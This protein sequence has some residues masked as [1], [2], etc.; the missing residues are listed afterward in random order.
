MIIA[1]TLSNYNNKHV[2]VNAPIINNV[3]WDGTFEKIIYSNELITLDGI[4]L[5]IPIICT[6]GDKYYNKTK[7]VFNPHLYTNIIEQLRS[8]EHN[9]LSLSSTNIYKQPSIYEQLKNG[10]IKVNDSE[11]G[12]PEGSDD[13]LYTFVLKMSGI[14]EKYNC[15]G[16]TFKFILQKCT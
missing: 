13:D 1:N 2:Y 6:K 3:M 16:I 15:R 4:Y 5:H 12:G 11:L 8:I 9:L 10:H 14:W 7:Y